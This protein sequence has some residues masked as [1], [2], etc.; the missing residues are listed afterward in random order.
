MEQQRRRRPK[1]A[2]TCAEREH[3]RAL[4]RRHGSGG[5][6]DEM[7]GH[8]RPPHP[9]HCSVLHPQSAYLYALLPVSVSLSLFPSSWC[10]SAALSAHW[11]AKELV[12]LA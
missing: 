3:V 10:D 1:S 8:H 7:T 5:R 12:I 6:P 9:R 2:S 4:R 11:R